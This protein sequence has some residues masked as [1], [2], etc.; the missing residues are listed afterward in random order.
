MHFKLWRDIL[1]NLD[2]AVAVIEKDFKIVLANRS[3]A[4]LSGLGDGI[5]G[6][7][8]FEVFPSL[9]ESAEGMEHGGRLYRITRLPIV[10]K[11]EKV[12]TI[13]RD[14]T[15]ERAMPEIGRN[16]DFLERIVESLGHGVAVIDDKY[17]ILMSNR[18]YAEMCGMSK[19][20]IIGK[21]C[22]EVAHLQGWPC[23]EEKES[24]PVLEVFST[25]NPFSVVH[26]HH[27][28]SG[29]T[30]YAEINAYPLKNDRDEVNLVLEVV[31]DITERYELEKKLKETGEFLNNIMKSSGD[32]IVATDLEGRITFWSQGAEKLFGYTAE[33]MLGKNIYDLHPEEFRLKR[34]RMEEF[35]LE[36]LEDAIRNYRMKI[37]RKDGKLVDISLSL[38][39][40]KDASGRPIGMVGISKDITREVKAEEEL[41]RKVRELEDFY[42]MAIGREMKMIELKNEIAKLREEIR[43]LRGEL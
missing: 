4:E 11:G 6:K 32:A 33:E 41:K 12:L 38:S 13:I 5:T 36:Y 31:N 18:A 40:L 34:K 39:L 26:R 24:C 43:R 15:E 22:Y 37:Y 35:L 30:Y 19:A 27:T 20:E 14:V 7:K 17:R 28:R 8:L 16:K 21:K 1:E 23:A 29:R 3:F 25:G 42:N 2:D 10:M 9:T